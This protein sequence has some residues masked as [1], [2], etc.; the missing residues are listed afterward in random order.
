MPRQRHLDARANTTAPVPV[1]T[2]AYVMRG[3]DFRWNH[4][5]PWSVA[6]GQVP[7]PLLSVNRNLTVTGTNGALQDSPLPT[8]TPRR[9]LHGNLSPEYQDQPRFRTDVGT[10]M[11]AVREGR[12]T[13]QTHLGR[14][15]MARTADSP[16]G[17]QNPVPT[18]GLMLR[19][20]P[21]IPEQPQ[22]TGGFPQPCP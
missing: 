4:P 10:P 15:A 8:P 6:T 22:N 5:W 14:Q 18:P 11:G 2:P 1:V 7:A 13:A 21:T 12:L 19:V 17:L 3:L 20:V 9:V 16:P